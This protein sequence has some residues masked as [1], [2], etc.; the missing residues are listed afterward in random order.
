MFYSKAAVFEKCAVSYAKSDKG[1]LQNS[2]FFSG[3]KSVNKFMM[4]KKF[5]IDFF[6]NCR[7][8]YTFGNDSIARL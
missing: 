6:S 3:I 5:N 8:I 2:F 1:I 7:L 4:Y